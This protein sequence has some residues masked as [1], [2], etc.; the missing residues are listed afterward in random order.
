MKVVAGENSYV[1]I[2]DGV[3]GYLSHSDMPLYF[4]LGESAKV[5]KIE[6]SW[7][8]GKLQTLSGPIEINR[9]LEITEEGE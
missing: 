3:S 6:V 9:R 2:N 1:Q 8:S 4:G 5:D 7:P